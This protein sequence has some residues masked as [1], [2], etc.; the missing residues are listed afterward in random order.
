MPAAP[1]VVLTAVPPLDQLQGARRLVLGARRR[2]R[3]RA[4]A[5][6]RTT[7]GSS[8]PAHRRYATACSSGSDGWRRRAP[9]CATGA[10][11]ARRRCVPDGR[12][13]AVDDRVRD[14]RRRRRAPTAGRAPARCRARIH[15][16]SARS[17]DRVDDRVGVLR[18]RDGSRRH[19][20]GSRRAR[21]SRSPGGRSRTARRSALR[22]RSM[23]TTQL[24]LREGLAEAFLAR[25][26]H[27]RVAADD[28]QRAQRVAWAPATYSAQEV[29]RD[30]APHVAHGADRG[31]E[32]RLGELGR[33][34]RVGGLAGGAR[35]RGDARLPVT[36]FSICS[37]QYTSVPWRPMFPP[38]PMCAIAVG[39][40]RRSRAPYAGCRRA[41]SP[42]TPATESASNG[43]TN[44]R[45]PSTLRRVLAQE[46]VV[47]S[48]EPVDLGEQ[49]RE[50]VER[51]CRAGSGG[52]RRVPSSTARMR[53][54]FTKVTWP[55][56][57][58]G[59]RGWPRSRW[60]PRRRSRWLPLGSVPRQRKKSVWYRS[61][62]GNILGARP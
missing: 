51:R 20:S 61:G 31:V 2:S 58:L 35:R 59:C 25:D 19:R 40:R 39:A 26:R 9:W 46:V 5:P 7:A 27:D 12:A 44:S 34:A 22:K 21:A 38:V 3:G 36:R 16:S 48:A 18:G 52:G 29:R 37:N 45:R 24:E 11:A 30:V 47:P 60:A 4:R 15:H 28:E 1:G 6:A 62:A 32:E 43:A 8:R 56:R 41:S 33:S 17:P 50:E 55:P 42:V 54:G 57:S 53:R 14:R 13:I 49:R 10:S 23:V